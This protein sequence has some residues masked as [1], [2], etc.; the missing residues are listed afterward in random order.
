MKKPKA[1]VQAKA[2]AT[3]EKRAITTRQQFDAVIADKQPILLLLN[4]V[5]KKFETVPPDQCGR[6][7]LSDRYNAIDTLIKNDRVFY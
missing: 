4:V 3:V 1:D 5:E 6:W 2:V 7:V